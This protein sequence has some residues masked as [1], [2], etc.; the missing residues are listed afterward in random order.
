MSIISVINKDFLVYIRHRKTLL[1][2]FLAPI[3]IMILIGSVFSGASGE[4]LKEVKLGV[5]G[6][7]T[8]GNDIIE[9][10]NSSKMFIIVKENTFDPSVIED[11]VKKGK[12][13][14]G[15]FIPEN[16]TQ[17]MKL[18]I[19]NSRVQIAPVISTV[20][21]T[22]TEKMSYVLTLGFISKLW[23]NLGEMESE[24]GPLKEGVF[25]INGNI[26]RLNNDT[27]NVLVRLD[28]INVTRMN[29]SINMMKTT[30][31]QMGID[32][33][34]TSV[35]INTTRND[36][37]EL[38]KNVSS[39]Y[40]DSAALRDDLKLVVDNIDSTDAALLAIQADLQS[41]YHSTCAIP[42]TP[43]CISIANTVLQIQNTRALLL[44]K[45]D[46]I[47]SLYNGLANVAQKGS[48]LHEKLIR[49]DIRL[50]N[51]QALIGNYIFEITNIQGNI[52]TIQ[53]A[54]VILEKVKTQSANVSIQMNNLST[55]MENSTSNL[56]SEINLT[57]G[58]LGDVRNKSPAAIAAPIKLEREQV[59]KD[60]S[61]LDFLMPAIV[62]I[63]L[64]FISFLL[65]SITIVQERTKKTLL[66]T[67]LTP[68][69][70]EEFIFAKTLALI[71]IAMLQG[72]I[73][74]VVAFLFYGI[75]IPASQLG[76][77]FLVILVYSAAFIGIGMA[78]ATFAESENTAMLSSLVL[79]I[80]MLFLCGVFF[81]FETMPQLMVKIGSALPITMG[82]RA[83]DSVLIYQEG[84][85]ALS[86]YLLPLLLYGIAGLGMAYILLRKEIMD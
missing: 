24:L 27:Q 70:L 30:L 84:F 22:T 72:I 37:L 42:S 86:G 63:V 16:Q 14:A 7:S 4:G 82:I 38:D 35:D 23:E 71:L 45:T 34:R 36:I 8:L 62:S 56:I 25:L 39:I 75:L 1:L 74:V 55:E 5:G 10:L 6:G 2:I 50:Q 51:M 40:N 77:L 21:L 68:L 57:K 79:S 41:T 59:F 78:V 53:T 13:S 65:S 20:F 19:D 52:S 76:L 47:R 17:S 3:L 15:I 64:M 54:I 48:E 80:P 32:L 73:L 69:S 28:E 85:G 67:L 26:S 31:D 11:G 61:Y 12:Y 9:E 18:Y 29:K 46:R 33:S 43:Q 60:M 49:T 44:E 58:I 66:R 83:L 81:P